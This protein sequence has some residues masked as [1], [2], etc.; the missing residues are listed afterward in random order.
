MQNIAGAH[1]PLHKRAKAILTAHGDKLQD[2]RRSDDLVFLNAMV[3][4]HMVWGT[5]KQQKKLD[6]IEAEFPLSDI[7]MAQIDPDVNCCVIPKRT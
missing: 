7:Q 6:E 5:E 2:E 3:N 4:K 1:T